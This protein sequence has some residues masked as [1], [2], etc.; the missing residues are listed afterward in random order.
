M[1]E[2]ALF[3]VA[4]WVLNQLGSKLLQEASLL[5]GVEDD[6]HKLTRTLSTIHALLLDADQKSSSSSSSQTHQL[7]LWLKE[8]SEVVYDA[9]DLL[10]EFSTELRRRRHGTL[11]TASGTQRISKEVTNFFSSSNQVAYGLKIAHGIQEIRARID[12]IAE[13]GSMF[14]LLERH[15][16][17][18]DSVGRKERDQTH[19]GVPHVVIGRGEDKEKI[20]ELLLSSNCRDNV[21]VVPIVGI[22]GLGKTT[23]AQLVYNDDRV[24][25]HYDIAAWVC[26]SENFDVKLVVEK[27]VESCTGEKPRGNLEMDS[28]RKRLHEIINGRKYLVVLDDV[29]NEDREKWSRLKSLFTGG[30]NGCSLMITTRLKKV[31]RLATLRMEPYEL[32]GLSESESWS[33]F[34]EMAFEGGEVTSVNHERIGREIVE[35]CKGVP[36][37]VRTIAG[38]LLFRETESEWAEFRSKEIWE[39]DQDQSDIMPTLKLSYDHLPTHLK[40]C[41]A[42]CRLFPKDYEMNVKTLIQLWIAQGYVSSSDLSSQ[43]TVGLEYFKDLLWRSF[44]QEVKQDKW[45]NIVSCKMHDLIHDLAVAVAGEESLTLEISSSLDIPSYD[46]R[47][48]R[49]RHVSLD[50]KVRFPEELCQVSSFIVNNAY[51]LRTFLGIRKPLFWNSNVFDSIVFSN[52]TRLR[53]L[54]LSYFKMM[55]ISQTIHKLKHLRY[56]DLSG[57]NMTTLPEEI[58]ELVNLEVLMLKDCRL[59]EKLPKGTGNLSNLTHLA[60]GGCPALICLPFG[61]GKLCYLR[62]LSRFLLAEGDIKCS[63]TAASAAGIGELQ[64]L[65][66]LRGTL[67]MDNLER[68]NNPSEG[69]MANLKDKQYLE[70]L[71]LSWESGRDNADVIAEGKLLEALRPHPNLKALSLDSNAGLKCPSWLSSITNLVEIRIEGS[72]N[73][74]SI[75]PLDQLPFLAR[76][77]LSCL[78]SLEYIKSGVTPTLSSAASSTFYPSLKFLKLEGCPKLKGWSTPSELLPQFPCVSEVTINS[79]DSIT[80][81]PRFS[82]HLQHL[83]LIGGS[84]DLLNQ[85]LRINPSSSQPF[86]SGLEYLYIAELLDFDTLPEDILLR[87]SSSLKELEISDCPVLRTLSPAL[88]HHLTSLQKLCI[89]GC[90]ELDLSDHGTAMDG[91]DDEPKQLN[92][93]LLPRL[94]YVDFKAIPNLT[95]LPDWLQLALNLKQIE[96][97]DCPIQCIPEWMPK[98]SKLELLNM[99]H[100]GRTVKECMVED[101]PKIAHIPN[102]I[103]NKVYLKKDG[104][105]QPLSEEMEE[106]N[107]LNTIEVLGFFVGQLSSGSEE[108]GG[109]GGG[110]ETSKLVQLFRN[111]SSRLAATLNI[112]CR[113]FQA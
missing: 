74:K 13:R 99:R 55:V 49:I 95:L 113:C 40:H 9:Q 109:G 75:P 66:N 3:N 61:I 43:H 7:Q 39:M 65:N 108:V 62:E 25:S 35:K 73:W 72:P 97:R 30:A 89:Y 31:A 12:E 2:A 107:H 17:V 47:L 36:L 101:W 79:C 10:D 59:L 14:N 70:Q 106:E 1:A 91:N 48:R 22:G 56:L 15:P 85:I 23:L 111:C 88:P 6:V 37:A 110:E 50:Y 58:T 87:L 60:L 78:D 103:I 18:D 52:T 45:G 19:S 38:A 76:L 27:I 28:L 98:L 77:E 80:S 44:F 94:S 26:V 54:D 57:N 71:L 33:L 84:K 67:M 102:I 42:Y 16:T 82:L 11:T 64:Y 46:V 21:S 4:D 20:V 112:F 41:F 29:W 34:R 69:E 90:E 81:V 68:V 53:V 92:G 83:T 104:F 5:W 32:K 105:C 93:A 63:S 100:Y 8:L 86:S 24:K 51:K 96:T